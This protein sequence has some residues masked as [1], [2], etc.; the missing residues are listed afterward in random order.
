MSTTTDNFLFETKTKNCSGH[1]YR[2]VHLDAFLKT[3]VEV[4]DHKCGKLL[5]V[6]HWTAF[7]KDLLVESRCRDSM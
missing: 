4:H 1:A 5:F 2:P 7:N 6:G 3:C